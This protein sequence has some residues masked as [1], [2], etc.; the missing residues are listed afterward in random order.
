MLRLQKILKL[1]R[2]LHLVSKKE[3]EM[4]KTVC[5]SAG[6]DPSEDNVAK[7]EMKDFDALKPPGLISFIL[8]RH[9]TLKTKSSIQNKYKKPRTALKDALENGAANLISVAYSLREVKSRLLATI[10]EDENTPEDNPPTGNDSPSTIHISLDPTIDDV[11]PS[12]LINDPQWIARVWSVLDPQDR[13]RKSIVDE[14]LAKKSDLLLSHLHSRLKAHISSDRIPLSKKEH[15]CLEWAR[16]NL[17]VVAA[18]MVLLDHV[19]KDIS[20]ISHSKCLLAKPNG[21]SLVTHGSST[22]SN[23]LLC[24]NTEALRQGCY[25]YYDTNEDEW[26]R[27]GKVTGPD[28]HFLARHLEHTK[29]A[30]DDKNIDDSDFYDRYPS[31]KSRRANSIAVDGNFENLRQ[32][33]GAAFSWTGDVKDM[34]QKDYGNGGIFGY[35]KEDM[36]N[37]QRV[38]FRGRSNEEKFIEM[39]GYLFELGYELALSRKY[40]VSQSPGFEGCGLRFQ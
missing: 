13:F 4:I 8:A 37:I 34:F 27:S 28:R 35:T 36:D 14:D 10:Q 33:V 1:K 21:G 18:Y 20:C 39:V 2:Q 22:S 3:V 30:E 25:L 19:K 16:K 32:F 26:I 40:N 9:P 38:N 17:S 6:L 23:F 15:W 5:E 31:L 12:N 7:C 24:T 11:K 29:R